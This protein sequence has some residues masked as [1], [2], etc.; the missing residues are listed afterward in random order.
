ALIEVVGYAPGETITLHFTKGEPT[1]TVLSI[2]AKPAAPAADAAG[3]S[4]AG[5][6]PATAPA[7]APAPAAK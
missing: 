5:L 6:P 4:A 1:S 2:G 7:A 3:G